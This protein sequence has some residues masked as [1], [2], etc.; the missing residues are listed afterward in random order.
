MSNVYTN[1]RSKFEFKPLGI[2]AAALFLLLALLSLL[3][4]VR[5][6]SPYDLFPDFGRDF[7][8]EILAVMTTVKTLTFPVAC[9]TFA[10]ILVMRKNRVN[11]SLIIGIYFAF[12]LLVPWILKLTL[13]YLHH[14]PVM[15]SWFYIW[16]DL[17]FIG[18]I[19]TLVFIL[20]SI[21][22]MVAKRKKATPTP[23][24]LMIPSAPSIPQSQPFPSPMGYGSAP[25]SNLPV[26]ALVAAFIIPIGAVIMGH[27]SLSQMNQGLI[28]SQNRGI[29]TAGLVLG[30]VFMAIGLVIGLILAF[31]PIF[32]RTY[33]Y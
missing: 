22:G 21:L 11:W 31:A 8:E 5:Y 32:A 33:Y 6:L 24:P 3:L 26:F 2:I 4:I 25:L 23:E 15:I 13:S 9:L 7:F 27:I 30:Y 17:E 29:A 19:G 12:S 1:S 16:P 20:A 14:W 28:S 18:F 10:F